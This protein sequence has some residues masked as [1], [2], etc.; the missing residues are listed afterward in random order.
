MLLLT[1]GLPVVMTFAWYHGERASRQFTKAELSILS[2]L[3]VMS[4]LLFY[5]FVR[6]SEE[7]AA[8][9]KPAVQPASVAA[10]RA[11]AASP[12]NAIS[13]AVL[14]FTNLSGDASQEFFSDGMTEEITSALAKVPDL[15]V[16]ARTS[17]FEFKDKNVNIKAM[18]QELGATHLIE[19]SV[20]KVGNRLRITAQL[21]K[22]DDGTHI[23]AESY[24]RDLIDIFAVQ[25]DIARAIT[26]S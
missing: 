9:P 20:R 6:P 1:L 4:S 2:A 12:K 14:P 16:V 19:G 21:I 5:A 23:W 3:L 15:H 18:G 17:A 13:I 8:G 22:A 26:A 10:A 25:E 24:D 7:V 11:A